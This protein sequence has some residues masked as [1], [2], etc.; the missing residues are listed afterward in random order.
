MLFHLFTFLLYYS[1]L[2]ERKK[3][4]AFGLHIYYRRVLFHL[5][6]IEGVYFTEV[7]RLSFPW[8][9]LS[10]C[11]VIDEANT[12][13]LYSAKCFDTLSPVWLFILVFLAVLLDVFEA[14]I[15]MESEVSPA[16]KKTLSLLLFL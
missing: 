13:I 14:V 9:F 4:Q 1:S 10:D 7:I 15:W 16:E 2:H 6:K 11:W 8:A 5:K 3:L 12:K